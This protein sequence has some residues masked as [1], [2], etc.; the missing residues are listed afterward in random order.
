MTKVFN[1]IFISAAVCLASTGSTVKSV[2]VDTQQ[3]Q[4]DNLYVCSFWPTCRDPDE[5]SPKPVPTDS[6][7]PKPTGDKDTTKDKKDESR[8]A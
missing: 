7:A 1:V 2:T 3:L 8:L 6:S 4:L 5:Q